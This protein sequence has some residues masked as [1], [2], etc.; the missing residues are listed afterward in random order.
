MTERTADPAVDGP[1]P[2][3]HLERDLRLIQRYTFIHSDAPFTSGVPLVGPVIVLVERAARRVLRAASGG[4]LGSQ[5]EFNAAVAEILFEFTRRAA[6]PEPLALNPDALEQALAL[7]SR[8]DGEQARALSLLVR[9]VQLL[10][11]QVRAAQLSAA[12]GERKMAELSRRLAE[13]EKER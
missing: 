9:Q 2:L 3:A 1:L 4:V 12:D 10:E 11:Q 13:L 7:I 8:S 5:S 6:S